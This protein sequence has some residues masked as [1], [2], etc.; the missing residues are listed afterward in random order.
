M[1]HNSRALKLAS[2]LLRPSMAVSFFVAQ[3]LAS[4]TTYLTNDPVVLAIG[5]IVTASGV[6]VWWSGSAAL[7]GSQ[8]IEKLATNG[9][10]KYVRHPI[11]VGMYILFLGIGLVFFSWWWF[12]VMIVFA[13]FWYLECRAEEEELMKR[14]GDEYAEYK[15]GT[16]MFLP[17]TK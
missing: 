9:P 15:K 16:G 6:A 17:K 14:Y 12:I 10:Y 4:R 8:R 5:V 11:Y 2:R 13:P 7:R 3:L 1:S